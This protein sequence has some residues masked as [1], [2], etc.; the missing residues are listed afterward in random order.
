MA[1]SDARLDIDQVQRFVWLYQEIRPLTTGELWAL[2]VMLRLSILTVLAQVAGQITR[3][4]SPIA[5]TPTKGGPP[6]LTLAGALTGDEVVANCFTSL[7]AIA[8][9]D[10]MDFFEH[11]SRVEQILRGDPADVYAGMDR[12][13]RNR[14]RKV[15]EDLALA[16]GQSELDVARMADTLAQA[17]WTGHSPH[18]PAPDS[19]AA[20]LRMT[21]PAGGAAAWPGLDMPPSAHVGYY[22]WTTAARRLR[23]DWA[24]GPRR[25]PAWRVRP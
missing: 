3:P 25:Q 23:R 13:T 18:L 12:A 7:R 2:P 22:C 9:Y 24:T 17:A 21:G 4:G 8:T 16:T 6:P 14:Y 15:I 10:W 11:V 20:G 19:S 1:S 5:E